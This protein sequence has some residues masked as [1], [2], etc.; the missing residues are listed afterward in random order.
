MMIAPTSKAAT[1]A[2]SSSMSLWILRREQPRARVVIPDHKA[3][4]PGTLHQILKAAGLT[5]DDLLRLL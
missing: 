3:I 5:V 2:G 1:F 4:R